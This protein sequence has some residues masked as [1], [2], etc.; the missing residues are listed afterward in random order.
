MA[1]DDKLSAE[2]RRAVAGFL[3]RFE[4]DGWATTG[5]TYGT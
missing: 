4:R 1:S 2:D 5:F 3:T